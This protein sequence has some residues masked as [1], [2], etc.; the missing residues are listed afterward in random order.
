METFSTPN[1]GYLL[2]CANDFTGVGW[3]L[4]TWDPGGSCQIL[5]PDPTTDIRDPQDYFQ[6]TGAGVLECIDLDQEVC[7]TSPSLT[8]IATGNISFTADISW[9]GF[10]VLQTPPTDGINVE[11][12]I[13]G[14]AWVRH[15]NILGVNGDPTYTVR[16][17][18]GIGPF[19][20]SGTTN[21]PSIA[22]TAGNSF[23]VRMC[24]SDNANAEVVTLDNVA[25]TGVSAGGCIAPTIGIATTQA[26]TCNGTNGSIIVTATGGTPGYNV[27]WSGTESG[28]PGGTEIASSGGMYAIT[29]LDDGPYTITVTDAASCTATATASVTIASA[30]APSTQ[31]LNTT[32]IG[33]DDGEINV[34]V[35]NGVPPF[36]Y[37]WSNLPG[38]PDPQDQTG[39]APGTYSFTVTDNAGCTVSSSATVG[40][41]AP[42]AYLET[43]SV[44][45]RGYLLD[46]INDFVGVNWTLSNWPLQPPDPFG[47]DNEDS[48]STNGGSLIAIDLDQEVCWSSPVIDINPPGSGV[49][50]SVDLAWTGF[51]NDA[52]DYIN[53]KYSVDGG[54]FSTVPNQV[55][56]GIGTIQYT[57]GLENNGSTTVSVSG[58]SGSTLQIQVCGDF[59]ANLE[60]MSIDNVSVPSAQGLA[61]AQEINVK[62]A[63]ANISDGGSYN[64][65]N[66]NLGANS[67]K[68]FTIENLGDVTLNLTGAAPNYVVKG[69]AN[70]GDFTITQPVTNTINGGNSTTFTVQFTPGG[71]GAR[72]CTLSIANNDSNENPYDITL[73][74]T[75]TCPAITFTGTPTSTCSGTSNGQI[76]VSG[77]SGGTGPYMYSKD[78]G[79]NYQAGATFA[80]LAAN[81]YQVVVKDANG[82]TSGATPV[83]VD[84]FT[85]PP[86]N[87]TGADF[88][89]SNSAGNLYT[90]PV[91]MSAY[92]W[93]ISGDG[94]I[95]G[96]TTGQSVTVTSGN[97]INNYTVSVTVT[98]ANGCTSS[99]SKQSF[100]YLQKPTAD[101]TANPDPVCLGAILDLSIAAAASSTV[102]WTGEGIVNPNGNPSTTA[103]PTTSGSL[104][105]TVLVTA[106]NGCSNTGMVNVTVEDCD[107][108][109][110]GKIAWENDDVSGVKDATVNLTGS[111]SGSDVT[112]VNGEFSIMTSVP[113]GSFTLKPVKNTNKLNGVTTADAS[114]IQQHVAAIL[115]ITDPYKL[116]CADVN[117]SNSVSSLDASI[118]VQAVLGNPAALNQIKTSWRF[119]PSSY[120]LSV[121]PWGFPEQRTYTAITTSQTN[122]DFIGMKT[123]DVTGSANPANLVALE[124]LVLRADDRTLN[125]GEQISVAFTADHKDDIAAFQ[126]GLRFDPL[127]LEFVGV[128]PLAALP[129]TT[130]NFGL[131]NL[132][133]GE[134]RVAWAQA[135]G[136][137]IE[138]PAPVFQV[139]FKALASDVL[140]SDVLQSD[141]GILPGLAYT[142]ALEEMA[143]DL[144][145]GLVTG[146]NTPGTSDFALLQNRPNPFS[147]TTAIAFVL[148]ETCEAQLRIF[149]VSGKMLAER[150]GQYPAGRSEETFDLEGATGVLWYELTT[151]FGVLA[152]KMAAVQ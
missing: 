33:S 42:G 90:A 140:L 34:S 6:T 66:V 64:Y 37:S 142:G 114:A 111:A 125:S 136:V 28:N 25:V 52:F 84:A 50:F 24:A 89:C 128:E 5:P 44:A 123:G 127:L 39:L 40:V 88:V 69:G 58:I 74:G 78:N 137:D 19:N 146:T 108:D 147:G 18:D 43:F 53:V 91:G 81:T 99:C 151:P 47:R 2:N 51:D 63:A 26:G 103:Q 67:S 97:F 94:S 41:S 13:N 56:G 11:Y 86:C 149:D 68:V 92:N 98:D 119:V 60:T 129:L 100:I 80:G 131:F 36:T 93:S 150:K 113:S 85:P 71:V 96:L 116:V 145:F 29:G 87:V 126:Y 48:F 59:N 101:I 32:C 102:A 9:V 141:P 83:L 139:H 27:A 1:K 120:A 30:M 38:S 3:T 77:V 4:S 22:V 138:A 144:Q 130:D 70:S 135:T 16:Y 148:P 79:A 73:T 152:R 57:A 10:D 54:A 143:V 23:K 17:I 49:A 121:P 105:Y 72:S 14:G 61:C 134:I 117:K 95:Q 12:Q 20:S 21:F 104:T 107:I 75:G 15:P 112:D 106:D 8:V 46:F 122:Q 65:G 133:D 7:W 115:P 110:S 82:C 35:A 55:G 118:I 76:A 132:A 31:V 45:N 109:F 62:Q 124:P